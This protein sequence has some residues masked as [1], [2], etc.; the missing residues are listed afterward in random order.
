M[1][2]HC[3]ENV[4]MEQVDELMKFRDSAAEFDASKPDYLSLLDFNLDKYKVAPEAT[5]EEQEAPIQMTQSEV[6]MQTIVEVE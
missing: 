3:R 1:M 6:A 5:K 2:I 4:K